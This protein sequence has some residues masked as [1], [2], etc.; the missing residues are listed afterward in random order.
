MLF[1]LNT[2]VK[3]TIRQER[4]VV[5]WE[6][7]KHSSRMLTCSNDNYWEKRGN[8]PI[9]CQRVKFPF[10]KPVLTCPNIQ[11]VSQHASGQGDVDRGLCTVVV[12]SPVMVTEAGGTH[13]TGLHSCPL[14]KLCGQTQQILSKELPR[15]TLIRKHWEQKYGL[16]LV[17]PLWGSHFS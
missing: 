12:Y 10:K 8:I 6:T 5:S 11:L 3:T 9:S 13:P 15:H 2:F 16:T 7:R 14:M 4:S 1:S 17:F